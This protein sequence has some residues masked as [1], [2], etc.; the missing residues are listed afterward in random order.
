MKSNRRI[1]SYLLLLA[2]G[3]VLIFWGAMETIDEFWSGMGGGLM[4]VSA[5]RLIQ[6]YR[7]RKNPA[8]QEQMDIEV[9]DERN[10]F[11][12]AKAWSWAGYLFILI[13]AV[14][15]IVLRVMGQVLLSMAASWAV[16][17]ML[18]LYWGAYMVLKK[19]Y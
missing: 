4:G 3:A 11:L 6:M 15:T 12:R 17:L 16:C 19:K 9:N 1:I 7:L 13:S 8:Y 18:V 5:L 14:A 10:R 2:L